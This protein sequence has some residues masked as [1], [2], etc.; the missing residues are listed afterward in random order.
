[1]Q[2]WTYPVRSTLANRIATPGTFYG[3][4]ASISR[5]FRPYA[6]PWGMKAADLATHCHSEGGARRVLPVL[7]VWRRLMNLLTRGRAQLPRGGPSGSHF[8]FARRLAVLRRASDP[9]R[10][11]NPNPA[12]ERILRGR[13]ST[14]GSVYGSRSGGLCAMAV[15]HL[16]RHHRAPS[17]KRGC[18][19]RAGSGRSTKGLTHRAARRPIRVRSS[20]SQPFRFAGFHWVSYAFAVSFPSA[21]G[22]ILR[23]A[24]ARSVP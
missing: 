2:D 20:R 10:A 15:I 21:H 19:P 23:S 13:R 1:M 18:R 11:G 24:P 6:H 4:P 9:A 12:E 7:D 8:P 22:V 16:R 3:P 17:K 5:V 14:A